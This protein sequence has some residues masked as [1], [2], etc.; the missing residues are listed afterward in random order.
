MPRPLDAHNIYLGS[1]GRMG[2]YGYE[3]QNFTG[4]IETSEHR[5]LVSRH[6][7]VL[8]RSRYPEPFR[9]GLKHFPANGRASMVDRIGRSSDRAAL[10]FRT[11]FNQRTVAAFGARRRLYRPVHP[12]TTGAAND[13]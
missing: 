13:D 8:D 10:G 4:R 5:E 1:E 12:S 9:K 7:V 3:A 6:H 11:S 2:L